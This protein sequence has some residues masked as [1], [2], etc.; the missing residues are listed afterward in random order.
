MDQPHRSPDMETNP[1]QTET[2]F[3]PSIKKEGFINKHAAC[4]SN[5][6]PAQPTSIHHCVL[7]SFM[8]NSQIWLQAV[9]IRDHVFFIPVDIQ[10]SPL[11]SHKLIKTDTHI[12][13][14][15][16]HK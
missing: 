7:S 2:F 14:L 3:Q 11:Q 10:M 1:N 8:I 16:W 13:Q 12:H 5:K 6:T 15:T 9:F 4:L